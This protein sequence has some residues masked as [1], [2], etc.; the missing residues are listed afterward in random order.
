MLSP[1]VAR[2]LT[3]VLKGSEKGVRRGVARGYRYGFEREVGETVVGSQYSRSI[4]TE[5]APREQY[6]DLSLA[7]KAGFAAGRTAADVM[8]SGTRAIAEFNMSNIYDLMASYGYKQARKMAPNAPPWLAATAPVVAGA[9]IYQLGTGRLFGA[10]P[11]EEQALSPRQARSFRE[12]QQA[13]QDPNDPAY[14]PSF[15]QMP[16]QEQQ[17]AYEG[18]LKEQYS[19]DTERAR[20]V[21]QWLGNDDP[22]KPKN[23]IGERVQRGLFQQAGS[24][25]PYDKL[26][27]VRNDITYE[28]YQ[29]YRT[30]LSAGRGEFG[31]YGG[32]GYGGFNVGLRGK[33]IYNSPISGG[34]EV[35]IGSAA[36]P[37]Y[38]AAGAIGASTYAVPRLLGKLYKDRTPPSE[39]PST[40]PPTQAPRAKTATPRTAQPN[41]TQSNPTQLNPTQ[42]RPRVSTP[43]TGTPQSAPKTAKAPPRP[44]DAYEQAYQYA[45]SK[46]LRSTD[47]I[48]NAIQYAPGLPQDDLSRQAIAQQF[49]QRMSR[50]ASKPI[51]GDLGF[52]TQQDFAPAGL[53]Q[54]TGMK[55][56][57]RRAMGL[58][59]GDGGG[60]SS[61]PNTR[62]RGFLQQSLDDARNRGDMDAAKAWQDE[63]LKL[64]RDK[65]AGDIA[66]RNQQQT[67]LFGATEYS[68]DMPLFS[69]QTPSPDEF[70]ID[71]LFR[72]AETALEGMGDDLK[73]AGKN[74]FQS[75]LER[76]K[77]YRENLLEINQQAP[78]L[79]D[80]AKVDAGEAQQL[81][82]MLGKMTE[83]GMSPDDIKQAMK[84]AGAFSEQPKSAKLPKWYESTR[85]QAQPATPEAPKVAKPTRGAKIQQKVDTLKQLAAADTRNAAEIY[86]VA[87]VA[88]NKLAEQQAPKVAQLPAGKAKPPRSPQPLV[89]DAPLTRA[90]RT[91]RTQR[92]RMTYLARAQ[93]LDVQFTND[94]NF[95]S[96]TTI[97]DLKTGQGTEYRN[98]GEALTALESSFKQSQQPA[99]RSPR[100]AQLAKSAPTPKAARVAAVAQSAEKVLRQQYTPT[101]PEVREP[102]V[103]RMP[104]DNTKVDLGIRTPTESQ[105]SLPEL[106]AEADRIGSKYQTPTEQ[107][108]YQRQL[109]QAR[110]SPPTESL[111]GDL[112]RNLTPAQLRG[113]VDE[114]IISGWESDETLA[115]R[116]RGLRIEDSRQDMTVMRDLQ[117]TIKQ[118]DS[119]GQDQA[120]MRDLRN[121]QRQADRLIPMQQYPPI[122]PTTPRRSPPRISAPTPGPQI[123]PRLPRN[124]PTVYTPRTLATTKKP[125]LTSL[126]AERSLTTPAPRNLPSVAKVDNLADS[127]N[128]RHGKIGQPTRISTPT[129]KARLP[130]GVG[131][132]AGLVGEV[133]GNLI[134]PALEYRAATQEGASNKRAAARATVELGKQNLSSAIDY[135]Q[136]PIAGGINA[137]GNLGESIGLLTGNETIRNAGRATKRVIEQFSPAARASNRLQELDPNAVVDLAKNQFVSKGTKSNFAGIGQ[138]LSQTAA[139]LQAIAE[140]KARPDTFRQQIARQDKQRQLEQRQ[141][142]ARKDA[143]LQQSRNLVAQQ[144]SRGVTTPTDVLASGLLKN[145][146][147][148][149]GLRR[150]TRGQSPLLPGGQRVNQAYSKSN[151]SKA[152]A[153]LNLTQD[154]ADDQLLKA[155]AENKIEMRN[156]KPTP[157]PNTTGTQVRGKVTRI[158]DGD[159]VEVRAYN[160]TSKTFENRRVRIAEINAPEKNTPNG[161]RAT[162]YAQQQLKPGSL[163]YMTGQGTDK[164]GR[165]LRSVAP[166]N[167]PA[168]NF[169]QGAM[170]S[171]NAKP[172]T[173]STNYTPPGQAPTGSKFSSGNKGGLSV[174]DRIK[175]DN[176]RQDRIDKRT[177]ATN[178]NRV[179]IATDR[180]K[181]TIRGQ[182][183]RSRDTQRGQN[184]RLIGV[185]ETNQSRE[186]IAGQKDTT[187]RRG[188]DIR[189]GDSRYVANSRLKGTMY[190]ADQRLRGQIGS[191]QI[192]AGATIGSAQI[193]ADSTVKVA[194]IKLTGTKYTADRRLEGEDLKSSR[195]LTGDM[196]SADSKVIA[197]QEQAEAKKRAAQWAA[198][199]NMNAAALK[200]GYAVGDS[201]ARIYSR[202]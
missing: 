177:G 12:F 179:K 1:R 159:T 201:L 142:Q 161:P 66:R 40:P 133:A 119:Y 30:A 70:D 49:Q 59:M 84:E 63:I 173:G 155:S 10:R 132:A 47:E 88:T 83:L 58:R 156:G 27:E 180:N 48:L 147:G 3:K 153:R 9:G 171:G 38:V 87:Q 154:Q 126:P 51:Q 95:V 105:Q 100:L 167:Q 112:R 202:R 22:T 62:D 113:E 18:L 181:V 78:G 55:G 25:L 160:P 79:V 60:S 54:R 187:T 184:L 146:G 21:K 96:P 61:L 189:S 135:A 166:D 176:N 183:T 4:L 8:G 19:K 99:P 110:T 145:I 188:Q 52:R 120:V 32:D 200:S 196:Y 151:F 6:E 192:R 115:R 138:S 182:D 197:A 20:Q 130:K 128:T 116:T 172:Y 13:T 42:P 152:G 175:I 93:N 57:S 64:D 106:F 53:R 92:E 101:Q 28:E 108:S 26:Q 125:A 165:S 141:A 5:R 91:P 136:N 72:Q 73:S 131:K 170:Q 195:K 80:M 11:K 168:K 23:P 35:Q 34:P 68:S 44:N 117:R 111:L 150:G 162:Q 107:A 194:D 98:Q 169:S 137:A 109:Q 185:R 134:G 77:L 24:L 143:S 122:D 7:G 69:Q 163:I 29:K 50:E 140:T 46:N 149:E 82:G 198:L 16:I 157:T 94:R 75:D 104:T 76:A 124:L 114:R 85:G 36:M 17:K 127:L 39:P 33:V 43:N 121:V 102:R 118:A 89:I 31:L 164:Y 190:S 199:Q 14:E 45:K 191:A 186:K 97:V 90:Q 56:R 37:W 178:T 129:P 71:D 139:T 123:S 144:R 86:T 103:Y 2:N 174:E 148:A 81:R 67:S 15:I 41:S 193:K 158:V 65:L 74:I